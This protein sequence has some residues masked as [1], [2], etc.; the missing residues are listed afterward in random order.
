MEWDVVHED[1][2]RHVVPHQPHLAV[3]LGHGDVAG[4]DHDLLGERGGDL[5]EARL[6]NEHVH[7]QIPR[8]ARLSRAVAERDRA[9]DRVRQPSLAERAVH[10][11]Q[12]LAQD[13]H[14]AAR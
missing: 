9:S 8:A 4:S 3:A 1:V 10:G 11:Q 7:I 12:T 13:T 5:P 6:P 14:A 2:D